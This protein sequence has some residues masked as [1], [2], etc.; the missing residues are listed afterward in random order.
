VS[1]FS[2]NVPKKSSPKNKRGYTAQ[3]LIRSIEKYRLLREG[4]RVGVAVS[5]GA[6]SVA[7]L[8]LLL[9]LQ[10]KLGIALY[11][12][13]FHHQLRARAADAD[14][15]FVSRLAAKHKLPFIRGTA[16][17]NAIARREKSNLE[18][19]ARRARY[20]FFAQTA[21]QHNLAKIAVA[22]IADDQAETVLAHILRGTGLAGLG[23]I[24][25]QAGK[26]VRPLL[27]ASRADVHAFLKS[28][29]QPW[30]E[31]ATN[32]DITKTRARI[33][34]KLLPLLKKQFQPRVV[35]HLAAL[36]AHAR[37][38]NAL[39]DH[40]AEEFLAANLTFVPEG[41]SVRVMDL[42]TNSFEPRTAV[43]IDAP[44]SHDGA[45]SGLASRLIRL[46]V[47]RLKA[48]SAKSRSTELTALHVS[49]ILDLA[50]S[51]RTGAC[52]ALPGGIQVRRHSDRVVF[53]KK[54]PP[55]AQPEEPSVPIYQYK[56]DSLSGATLVRVPALRCAFRFTVIDCFG[57]R[58]ETSR[59]GEVLNGDLLS[60]PLTLR[61]WRYGDRFR[62]RGHAKPQKLKRLFNEKRIDRWQRHGWPVL[63]SGGILAWS[64]G[65]GSSADYAADGETHT[66]IV[67]AEEKST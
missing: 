57:K 21:E 26:I 53:C 59:S 19:A 61:N 55:E 13:H 44:P 27:S 54:A 40:L 30:R 48:E 18:D 7:L 47:R 45:S 20:A 39:L 34:E 8:L 37:R 36:S 3:L 22:H 35:E 5:G 28:R 1:G 10:P 64:R 67:I 49:Q 6:D 41:A 4:D 11:V 46:I 23:G 16:D 52:L 60:F 25:P 56:I 31:D 58:G 33:R 15:K 29:K 65:F 38:D 63:V 12:L 43:Q 50:R 32:R 17:V 2:N 66:G 24:H 9:D 62:A 14:E 51:G 42:L